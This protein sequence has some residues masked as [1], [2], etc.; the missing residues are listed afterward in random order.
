MKKP[1]GKEYLGQG[2]VILVLMLV[3][4]VFLALTIWFPVRGEVS[5]AV[6]PRLWIVGIY[7]CLIYLVVKILRKTEDPDEVAG[8]LILP[9][10]FIFATIGYIV[11]MVLIGYFLASLFFIAVTMTLLH[12]KRR[13]VILAISGGWM[14]FSYLIFYRVLYVPLPQGLLITAFFG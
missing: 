1:I 8:D 12:Y 13:F 2:T 3:S 10:K 14:V 4:A 11:L 6:V 7:S 9:F 5:A